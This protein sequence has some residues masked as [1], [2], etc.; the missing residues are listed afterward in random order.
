M[1]ACYLIAQN[2]DPG[3]EQTAFA[4]SYLELAFILKREKQTY[5]YRVPLFKKMVRDQDPV[6]LLSG[7]LFAIYF[8]LVTGHLL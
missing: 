6:V 1:P 4:Q 2:G 7:K 3:K 5:T 8:I